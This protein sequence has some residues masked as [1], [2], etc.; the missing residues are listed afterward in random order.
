MNYSSD[1]LTNKDDIPHTNNEPTT[2]N[3]TRNRS[4][5]TLILS[6][7]PSLFNNLRTSPL[8]HQNSDSSKE[9]GG[10]LRR[11]LGVSLNSSQEI[12]GSSNNEKVEKKRRQSASTRNS[13]DSVDSNEL[14]RN[15]D[16]IE[17][18]INRSQPGSM[19]IPEVFLEEGL[20]LLKVSR[21][22]K[23]RIYFQIDP[24][25]LT[26]KWR[27]ANKNQYSSNP[28][29]TNSK[30]G[31]D[32]NT[33][34]DDSITSGLQ[35]LLQF[36][37][38]P[39][40]LKKYYTF[41]I[42]DVKSVLL[43][44]NARNYRDEMNISKELEKQ[45][46]TLHYYYREKNKMKTLHLIADTEYDLKRFYNTIMNLKKLKTELSEN[47]YIDLDDM[48]EKQKQLI[49]SFSSNGHNQKQPKEFLSLDDVVKYM[50]R[51]NININKH[52][53]RTIFDS[54]SDKNGPIEPP[55]LDFEKFKEF[56]AILKKREDIVQIW[57]EVCDKPEDNHMGFASFENF[58]KNIQHEVLDNTLAQKIFDRFRKSDQGWDADSL[59][60]FLLSKYSK[61]IM[62]GEHEYSYYGFPLNEYFI[63]SSHNT[64][65]TGRQI[66]DD[67]STEGYTKALQ[68][69]C[70]CIEIDIWD[71]Q[72]EESDRAVPVV[73]HGKLFT[74]TISLKNV[75]TTIKKY[76][77][78]TS[79]FPLILSLEINCSVSNQYQVIEL[80]LETLAEFLVI[81][82]L[83]GVASLPSPNDL[84]HKILIK[85][86]KTSLFTNLYL[87]ESGTL[88]TMSTNTSTST[89][90]STS[91]TSFSE[92]N[93][94]GISNNNRH[95]KKRKHRKVVDELSDLA[96]YV[97]G[98][99]FRNF[100]LPESK[101]Y[102]HCFSLSERMVD[103]MLK[104]E[105]RRNAINKHN[106]RFLMRVYPSNMRLRST[107]F[108]PINYWL[109]G[110]QMVAT[111][112]QTYDL[113]QQINEAL[114]D[115]ADKA[116]Y[117]LK[118]K[119]IR[120]PVI[121]HTMRNLPSFTEKKIKF[122]IKI[123]SAHQL[124]KPNNFNIDTINPFVTL[125]IMGAQTVDIDE[126]ISECQTSVINDNGFNPIWNESFGGTISTNGFLFIKFSLNTAISKD[127]TAI[128]GTFLGKL[129]NLRQ[130]YRYLPLNDTLGEELIY[131]SLFVHIN[132]SE[133]SK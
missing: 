16:E 30:S 55:V 101:T 36:T 96:V 45:W 69:G 130:G 57:S 54:L 85:A 117:V 7:L 77:F 64:Y 66:A 22:S 92:D 71:G 91:N 82:P 1:A 41:S 50:Q 60:H 56:I 129:E 15:N 3:T 38:K 88:T 2:K 4:R 42:D 79:P 116:G 132:Y 123:I 53:L 25:T 131:S 103:S 63:S 9:S 102:N 74:S 49:L 32:L 35:K 113:G 8:D 97:Q 80:L 114:F 84:K 99:K 68:K 34:I 83:E 104:D 17:F 78:V 110:V 133:V 51:L 115:G 81:E 39:D 40:F 46:I 13:L 12:L 124:P 105:E 14:K 118:P 76:A 10:G 24:R 29:V 75:L 95:S 47:F 87:N 44:Q 26:F 86:K 127:S 90:T 33:D 122:R 58:L 61:P 125:E 93:S 89:S 108:L 106:R 100:S 119:D 72:D 65:L 31:S 126:G 5:S 27:V 109:H 62:D 19:S 111:N 37:H 73:C 121:K 120:K 48:D 59:N 98:Q 43:Q 21:K 112:W 94:T 107:N 28:N 70:R 11:L 52:Y 128:L 23:K 67:S 6:T 20:S 18:S